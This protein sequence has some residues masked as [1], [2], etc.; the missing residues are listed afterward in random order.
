MMAITNV[1]IPT[2]NPKVFA[3]LFSSASCRD[4]KKSIVLRQITIS[5]KVDG[6]KTLK[7]FDIISIKTPRSF[8]F[9][10]YRVYIYKQVMSSIEKDKRAAIICRPFAYLFEL[11]PV[12]KSILKL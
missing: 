8:I 10:T 6:Y 9:L 4:I 2:T 11:F 12:N 3:L 1:M 7:I 5:A